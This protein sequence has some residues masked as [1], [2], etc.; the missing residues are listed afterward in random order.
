MILS[1]LIYTILPPSSDVGAVSALQPAPAL[2]VLAIAFENGP[3][4]VR[5]VRVDKP[6]IRITP[7]SKMGP[8]TSISFR[9]DGM[10]AGYD[11]RL[12]GVMAT[13]GPQSGD[14]QFWDL[15]KSGR[16][17]GILRGAHSSQLKVPGGVGGGVNKVEFL[18]G[19]PVI[20]SS[21]L[22]NS[23][24]S[25]IFDEI[26]FSPIPRIL[27]CRSGHAAPVT[28]LSFLPSGADSADVE[29][30]WLLSAGV[31]R[32]LWGW[33]LRR[34]GQ[35]AELSQGNIKKK[36]KKLGLFAS[37]IEADEAGAGLQDLKTPEIICIAASL[38]RDGGIGA[39]PNAGP[40]WSN[41][42]INNRKKGAADASV[43]NLTGW[44]SIITGHKDNKIARTW[45]W[46]RKRAGRWAFETGDG[47][48][49]TV[50][51]SFRVDG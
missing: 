32:S 22:D 20:A 12:P 17:M 37:N 24:K 18:A 30:K 11:G 23:L 42:K 29:G 51:A 6:V 19:Q 28:R 35:S 8:V 9:T 48:N 43:Q 47:G 10:G 5:D 49:V 50:C 46:G 7:S 21:G 36:G 27:H 16:L 26:P 3:L 4:V 44:E 2:S 1:K 38:N 13:G 45:F 25:W 33:S 41:S 40:I 14:V 31:D 39:A 34:D 15:N